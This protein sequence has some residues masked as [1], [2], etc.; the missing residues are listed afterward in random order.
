MV[1]DYRELNLIS[2]SR[3]Q[4]Y[5][6]SSD[7]ESNDDQQARSLSISWIKPEYLQIDNERA[8][9]GISELPGCRYSIVRRSIEDDIVAC[10]LLLEMNPLLSAEEAIQVVR[11]IRGNAAIQTVAQYNFLMEYKTEAT[12]GPGPTGSMI[13]PRP[14]D[15]WQSV[16]R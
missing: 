9:I 1:K 10:A 6:S 15:T 14:S 12:S 2:T 3:N 16:I 7:D 11:D 4:V 8:L 13:D 5:D